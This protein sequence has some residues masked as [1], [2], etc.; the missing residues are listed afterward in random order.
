VIGPGVDGFVVNAFKP[1]G[2][3]SHD[4]VEIVRRALGTRKVG[5][6]GTLDPFATGVLLCCVGRATKLSGFLCDLTKEYEGTIL[7]GR[8]TASGDVTGEVIEDRELPLPDR[9]D[10]DAAARR[11]EGEIDQVP[12][13]VSALK[14]QGKRLYQLARRG[15]TVE[16]APRRVVVESFRILEAE[17][18]RIRFHVRCGRGTYV[19]VLA[20]DLAAGFGAGACVEDLCRTQVGPFAAGGAARLDGP[21]DGEELRR[22]A[23]PMAEALAHLPGWGVP[24]FWVRK[25]RDGQAPPWG[26]IEL[27]RPPRPGEIGRLLG[28]EGDLGAVARA[29]ET[30]GRAERPWQD[31]IGL[32]LL[33]VI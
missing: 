10:L 11:L 23:V 26:V 8:R 3:T 13:M 17:G 5:H 1:A 4:A 19:R 24:S 27:D 16:R 9:A 18:R 6:T 7:Y 31:A 12:P 30:P 21:P 29:V 2:C 14:H 25:L 15:I 28:G 22:R 33:R 32:E 20:E